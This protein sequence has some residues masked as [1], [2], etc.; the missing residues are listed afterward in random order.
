MR[1][2]QMTSRKTS[3]EEIGHRHYIQP[4][5]IMQEAVS[6]ISALCRWSPLAGVSIWHFSKLLTATPL[7]SLLNCFGASN[8]TLNAVQ[9]ALWPTMTEIAVPPSTCRG[10]LKKSAEPLVQ[11]HYNSLMYF[12]YPV[13]SIQCRAHFRHGALHSSICHLLLYS[14]HWHT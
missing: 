13:K 8:S 11:S 12:P 14:L 9:F 1:S 5:G 4:A 7:D 10:C 2:F 3:A 6:N